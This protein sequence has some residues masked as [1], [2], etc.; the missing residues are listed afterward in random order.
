MVPTLGA[1]IVMQLLGN[2]ALAGLS[3][4]MLNM[5][6]FVVSYPTG[7][8]ADT[9]GRRPAMTMGLSLGLI[10]AIIVG[11]SVTLQSFALFVLGMLAF[12]LGVGAA[13]QLRLAAADLYPP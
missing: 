8:V 1:L 12:G 10:G 3:T 6:R 11:A 13:Q 4:S 7:W 9:R 5:S 2:P